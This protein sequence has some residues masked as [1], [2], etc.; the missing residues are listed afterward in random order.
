MQLDAYLT[1]IRLNMATFLQSKMLFFLYSRS[2]RA[3]LGT[4]MACLTWFPRVGSGTPPPKCPN[5][6]SGV[7]EL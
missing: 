5:K 6:D 4:E 2:S 1:Y 7:R 3:N